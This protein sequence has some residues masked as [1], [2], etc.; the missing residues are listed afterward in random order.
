MK[1]SIS[2]TTE[3][4]Y[5]APVDYA[6]QKVRLR[7]MPSSMQ[8]VLDWT[9]EVTG[10]KVEASYTDHYGNHVDLVSIDHGA[11]VLSIHAI[12]HVNTLNN[13]GVLGPVYGVVP[14]WHF[15]QETPLTAAGK[16]IRALPRITGTSEHQISD[17]HNLSNAILEAL[18]YKFGGTGVDTPA[19][20]ALQG[21]H[22]VC[23]DHA[24]IFISAARLSGLPARY[25]SG[26]L[27][28]N[29]QIAQDATHAWAEV[30]IDGL[31]WVGF[32]ISNGVSPDERY[33][34][35]A[36]GRDARDAA[37]I[38]GLRMG[39]ADETLMVSLQVQQ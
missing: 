26:Y 13:S 17:L 22:A 25:V 15:L 8:E 35:I 24:Q 18:P 4:A 38:E 6:L 37:P 3:Y 23:Q 10:G 11:Q 20:E 21:G 33:V 2:H 9:V 29:D 1:L 5:S 27:M 12:G 28:I 7:P 31:G 39:T 34:R 14:L 16:A 19:E 30:C 32:D 36:I